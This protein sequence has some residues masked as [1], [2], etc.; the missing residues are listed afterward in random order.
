MGAVIGHAVIRN[1]VSRSRLWRDGVAWLLLAALASC[2]SPALDANSYRDKV[3]H[4]AES[5]GGIVRSAVLAARLDVDGKMLSTVTDTVVSQ[6]EQDAQSVVTALD[7]VQPPDA[8]SIKV[9]SD[10]DAVLQAASN[11]LSD[12]RIAVRRGD[13]ASMRDVLAQL[14]DAAHLVDVLAGRS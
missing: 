7:S 6:S 1:L 8:G 10:A 9:R 14:E 5:M 12:L 13:E 4:S 3:T 2:V 11:G